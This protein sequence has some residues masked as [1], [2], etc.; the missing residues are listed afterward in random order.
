MDSAVAEAIRL[1]L[2]EDRHSAPVASDI[3]IRYAKKH[4]SAS[5]KP[6]KDFGSSSKSPATLAE[7]SDIEFALQLSLA[8]EN[9]KIMDEDDFPALTISPSPLSSSDSGPQKREGKGKSRAT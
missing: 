1:S 9:S 3:P 6:M 5:P 7:E 4:H 8:E 2:L